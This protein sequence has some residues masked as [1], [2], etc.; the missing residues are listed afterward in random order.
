MVIS[1]SLCLKWQ[2]CTTGDWG[3]SLWECQGIHRQ[4]QKW[5]FPSVEQKSPLVLGSM[6]M[7]FCHMWCPVLI[8]ILSF[9]ISTVVQ[10]QSPL[11]TG[12]FFFFFFKSST[13]LGS[14]SR[15]LRNILGIRGI[16][17]ILLLR[18][19]LW[20]SF[21]AFI[22]SVKWWSD[23]YQ[24]FLVIVWEGKVIRMTACHSLSYL[25]LLI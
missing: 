25:T 17:Q 22:E 10:V 8:H 3:L 13:A 6:T 14:S 24:I 16:P 20:Y 21:T 4:K 15:P 19:I 5:G 11:V 2:G 7:S 18:S 1:H 12:F 23:N 9:Y